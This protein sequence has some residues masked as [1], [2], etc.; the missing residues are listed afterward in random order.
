MDKFLDWISNHT[1][2]ITLI[3]F[4]IVIL[5]GPFAIIFALKILFNLPHLEHVN[6]GTWMAA[7]IFLLVFGV[8]SK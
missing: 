1:V 8:K 3:L 2:A 5:F 4:A 7:L 6:F